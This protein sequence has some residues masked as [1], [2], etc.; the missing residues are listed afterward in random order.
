M[1]QYFHFFMNDRDTRTDICLSHGLG[2]HFV[3]VN[4]T[5]VEHVR[6]RFIHFFFAAVFENAFL[7]LNEVVVCSHL[8][9]FIF[10]E[11]VYIFFVLDLG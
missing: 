2:R 6:C 10:E 8:V 11:F 1:R 7:V 5:A 9:D 4:F 3:P